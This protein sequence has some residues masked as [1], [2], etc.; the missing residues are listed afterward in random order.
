MKKVILFIIALFIV[1][2]G[3]AIMIL[4]LAFSSNETATIYMPV[5]IIGGIL[6]LVLI[7]HHMYHLHTP[8][9]MK[10]LWISYFLLLLILCGVCEIVIHVY[11]RKVSPEQEP[12]LVEDPGYSV[13]YGKTKGCDVPGFLEVREIYY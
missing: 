8:Q 3:S 4:A 13:N 9:K 7:F 6:L 1:V 12:Y 11:K 10:R 2:W 5:I